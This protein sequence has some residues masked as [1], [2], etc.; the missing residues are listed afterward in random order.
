MRDLEQLSG[1]YGEMKRDLDDATGRALRAEA[2]RQ[3]LAEE[4]QVLPKIPDVHLIYEQYS[5]GQY[6][7]EQAKRAVLRAA[8]TRSSPRSCSRSRHGT[9]TS[10]SRRTPSSCRCVGEPC[11]RRQCD[12]ET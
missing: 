6:S 12:K 11:S 5:P 2:S 4:L 7:P 9:A 1:K 3:K 8:L 10:S